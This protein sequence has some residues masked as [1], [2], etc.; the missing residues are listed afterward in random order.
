MENRKYSVYVHRVITDCGPMY[1]AGCT[2]NIQNRWNPRSYVKRCSFGPYIDK[3]GWE[4][5]EHIVVMDGL[6][7]EKSMEVEDML[8]QM[9]W[10]LG[11]GINKKRSGLIEVSNTEEYRSNYNQKPEVK[12]RNRKRM[13]E[14][15]RQSD[16]KEKVKEYRTE[17]YKRPEVKERVNELNTRRNQKPE[18]KIYNRVTNWNRTHPDEICETPLEAKQK[19]IETGYIPNY[20]KNNDLL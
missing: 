11:C 8:I 18:R 9:Y 13:R 1:Y 12:E 15:M 17:Y 10:S 2:G 6:T 14:Y 5:I 20:I 19:Y 16:V 3:Y 4:N 7:Y